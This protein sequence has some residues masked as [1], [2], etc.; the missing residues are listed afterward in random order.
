MSFDAAFGRN[1]EYYEG[2]VFEITA[3]ADSGKQSDLP[4]L[5]GG[6]RYDAMTQRL[7]AA[8]PIPAVGGMIRPEAL[9]AARGAPP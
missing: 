4:P 2:F 3:P 8:Q 1:L 9:L 6:G 5:A 7:G